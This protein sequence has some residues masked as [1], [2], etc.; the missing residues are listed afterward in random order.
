MNIFYKK[1]LAE[2]IINLEEDMM[3]DLDEESDNACEPKLVKQLNAK[4]KKNI[5]NYLKC[6]QCYY[7][8]R[9]DV[10]MQRH[11]NT[12]HAHEKTKSSKNKEGNLFELDVVDGI[13]DFFRL[14]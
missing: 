11:K 8:A 10:S 13:D 1:K 7:I 3:E 14:K 12:K 6:A 2:I 4:H 5:V 9:T